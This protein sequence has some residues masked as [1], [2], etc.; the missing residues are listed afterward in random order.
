MNCCDYAPWS[1]IPNTSFLT[2]L[3][4]GRTKLECLS[5]VNLST[6]VFCDP[7]CLDTFV[8]CEEN[9]GL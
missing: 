8:N 5:L 3:K 9:D 1:F 7:S 4:N 6:L 2:Q